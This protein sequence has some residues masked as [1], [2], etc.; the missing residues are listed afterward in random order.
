MF[1][2]EKS[3]ML[4]AVDESSPLLSFETH[5]AEPDRKAA[6]GVFLA[7]I[8][9]VLVGM[10]NGMVFITNYVNIELIADKLGTTSLDIGSIFFVDAVGAV[11]GGLFWPMLSYFC[12]GGRTIFCCLIG[13]AALCIGIG[14]CTSLPLMYILY[15]VSALLISC[16]DTGTFAM[17]RVIHRGSDAVGPWFSAYCIV[18]RCGGLLAVLFNAV[19]T[20]VELIYGCVASIV[21]AI[22]IYSW[23]F[24]VEES[25]P[26]VEKGTVLEKLDLRLFVVEI[27]CGLALGCVDGTSSSITSYLETYIEQTGVIASN[28]ESYVVFVYWVAMIGGELAVLF[29]QEGCSTKTLLHLQIVCVTVAVTMLVLVLVFSG[30]ATYL[31]VAMVI[32]GFCNGAAFC[33]IGDVANRLSSPSALS[34]TIIFFGLSMLVSW[35]P[36]TVSAVWDYSDAGPQSLFYVIL[37]M[38]PFSLQVQLAPLY[39]RD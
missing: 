30:S 18:F 28:V 33:L 21:G 11:L 32:V 17:L 8:A 16:L 29:T 9:C 25:P 22:A 38:L 19:F 2:I 34:S 5:P 37:A 10:V 20:S 4:S 26:E 27:L 12:G 13:L 7:S 15:F 35:M 14:F 24:Q 23:L 36:Y 1:I 6:N 3:T 39:E 31:W